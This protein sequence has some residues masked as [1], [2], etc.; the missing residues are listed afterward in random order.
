[1]REDLP[2]G[3]VTFLFTDVEGST[4]LLREVGAETYA[5]ALGEHRRLIREACAAEGGVEV[6]TQGDAFFFAFPTAPGALAAGSAIADTLKEGPIQVRVGVHTGTPLL[7]GEGYVGDDVHRAARIAAAGHGGQVLVSAATQALVDVPLADLGAHRFKDLAAPERVFQVGSAAFPPLKTLHQT[8]LPIP[9]TPFLGRS[10][11]LA[12]VVALLTRDDVRLLTLTGPGG[13]GKTRLALQAAGQLSERYPD[14]VWWVPLAALRDASLVLGTASQALGARNGLAGHVADKRMLLLFDNFE[15][16]LEAAPGLAPVLA[17]CPNVEL[18]TTSREPLHLSGEQE[19]RVPPFVEDEAVDF[20][21]AKARSADSEFHADDVVPEICRRLDA[22][23]LALELAAARTTALSTRQ[24]LER[25]D[26]RLPLLTGGKADVPDRQR[27]LRATIEWSYDLLSPAEQVL[28]A[29][30]SVFAGGCTL[31][32]AEAVVD[33]D[34]DTLQSLTDKNLVRFTNERYW[35]LETIREFAANRLAETAKAGR[36]LALHADHYAG[37]VEGHAP[38]EDLDVWLDRVQADYPNVRTWLQHVERNEPARLLE[39]VVLLQFFWRHRG[40]LGEGRTWIEKALQADDGSSPGTRARALMGLSIILRAQGDMDGSWASAEEGLA[41]ARGA[42]DAR[43]VSLILTTLASVAADRH[44]V[45]RALVLQRESVDVART[46]EDTGPLAHGLNTLGYTLLIGGDAEG[47]IPAI[48]DALRLHS[49]NS[50]LIGQAI[51]L[52]NLG[53]AQLLAGRA[54]AARDSFLEAARTTATFGSDE[55][56]AYA[57]QGVAATTLDV[58]PRRAAELL[59]AADR[60]LDEAMASP[61]PVE[62]WVRQKALEGVTDALG[63]AAQEAMTVGRSLETT[64]A[65][66]RALD[67]APSSEG[68]A[69]PGGGSAGSSP[70]RS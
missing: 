60:L 14:G 30:L 49:E 66:Q 6:D 8:N 67:P 47:A 20:F 25:L 7:T 29:R 24:I 45:D 23:P 59:G 55:Y 53:A 65:I 11:E 69:A 12:D 32:A 58:D 35:M 13:T 18:L 61:E 3:T 62:Q 50:E 36:C 43:Q 68:S 16:V 37:L 17:E 1:V 42:G 52:L 38:D 44:E 28:F 54:E 39:R 27:T 56:V 64:A 9:S 31:D 26:R 57:L 48:E 2:T 46:L 34:L 21:A 41:A 63:D 33:A 40:Y 4:R 70:R 15:H 10:S 51:G 5:E 22:L 19:Y